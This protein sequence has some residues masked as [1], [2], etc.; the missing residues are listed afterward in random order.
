MIKREK[1]QER[2]TRIFLG[3]EGLNIIHG[4]LNK[5]GLFLLVQRR[6]RGDMA[7]VYKIINA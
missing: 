5:L 2:F 3:L 6:L 1:M 7:E 4:R